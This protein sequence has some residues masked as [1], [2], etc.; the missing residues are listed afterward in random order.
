[1][2]DPTDAPPP[3]SYQMSVEEFDQKTSQAMQLASS[4]PYPV[5]EDGWPIYDPAAFDAAAES[6][7]NPPSSSSSTGFPGSET[8]RQVRLG[9]PSS[10]K[11]KHSTRPTKVRSPF[12]LPFSG[13]VSNYPQFRPDCL[14]NTLCPRMN[15]LR[16]TA[17]HHHLHHSPR[18]VHLWTARRLKK[19]WPCPTMGQTH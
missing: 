3:P 5:D 8:N 13:P 14:N 16:R 17:A 7:E 18:L 10:E 12:L 6:Y 4:T 1:M 19:L 11:A 2:K 9:R 15:S